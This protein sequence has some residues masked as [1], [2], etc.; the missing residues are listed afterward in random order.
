MDYIINKNTF[1][2]QSDDDS[3]IIN[4]LS[5][6]LVVSGNQ[7]KSILERSC[8]YYGSSLQGRVVGARKLINSKYKI[9]I[10]ISE[11]NNIVFF[12][13]NGRKNGEIFWFNFGNIKHYGKCGEFV[14][15][16]FSDDQVRKFMIS[17]AVFNNQILK[18]SR[19]LVVYMNR[20]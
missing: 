12:P 7:V 5:T 14:N 10:M 20:G 13:I 4:E 17:Y 9:P 15:I 18:C 3:T 6:E 2:L 16:T 8:E 11:K 1:Y 19:L